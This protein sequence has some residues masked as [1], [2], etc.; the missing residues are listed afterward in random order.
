[1]LQESIQI[2]GA[3]GVLIRSRLVIGLRMLPEP[4]LSETVQP[5]S[6]LD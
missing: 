3:I 1:M 2:R 4:I 5:T 6:R